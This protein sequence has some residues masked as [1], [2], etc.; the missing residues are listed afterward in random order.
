MSQ[1]CCRRAF[2]AEGVQ[3]A[4]VVAKPPACDL[5]L[6]GYRVE[7]TKRF[8]FRGSLMEYQFQSAGPA[9]RVISLVFLLVFALAILGVIVLMA[10]LPGQIARR[11]H[12]RYAD[13]VSIAGWFGL[14]TGVIW[15]LAMVWAHI[16]P[17][18]SLNGASDSN[19]KR[20][21]VDQIDQLETLVERLEQDAKGRRSEDRHV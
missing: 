1:T 10:A 18:D 15:V 20:F 2:V 7:V 8:V 5:T 14:P 9:L 16:T 13:A 3:I 21:L 19:G 17:S 12:H 11:R 4:G 6:I